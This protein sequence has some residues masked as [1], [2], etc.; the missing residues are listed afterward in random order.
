M[1]A[2]AG[3][4][5][6]LAAQASQVSAS[7]PAGNSDV[8]SALPSWLLIALV[9]LVGLVVLAMFVLTGY[10]LSAP[11]ST[12]KNVLGRGGLFRR[13]AKDPVSE[14]LVRELAT[15]ARV[16]KRTTRTTLAIAGFALL[17]VVI[18]A[19]FGSSGQGVR[20]LRS[21]VVAS[22]TTLAATIA[23]FYFGAQ[24]AAK[25][26]AANAGGQAAAGPVPVLAP[27]PAPAAAESAD[28]GQASPAVQAGM[29]AP[30]PANAGNAGNF[31]AS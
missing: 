10:S 7:G 25:Q 30:D 23:G 19:I 16:G 3:T 22:V 1:Y 27:E 18:I 6:A 31:Q 8:A 9:A 29:F 24:T 28:V 2:A 11:R 17:G 4:L 14:D 12:L 26:G 20:D 15:S 13:K 5:A 21:Q